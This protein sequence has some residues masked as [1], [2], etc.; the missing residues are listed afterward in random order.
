MYLFVQKVNLEYDLS[1]LYSFGV[2]GLVSIYSIEGMIYCPGP[3]AILD[4][5]FMFMWNVAIGVRHA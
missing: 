4:D 1:I 3:S 2:S 5:R